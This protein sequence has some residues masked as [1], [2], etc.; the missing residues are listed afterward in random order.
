MFSL[1]SQT[2]QE[3][4]TETLQLKWASSTN[5]AKKTQRLS[6]HSKK[7]DSSKVYNVVQGSCHS[8]WSS[9]IL[10]FFW[11]PGRIGSV[12]LHQR[13]VQKK[14][15][16]RLLFFRAKRE[17]KDRCLTLKKGGNGRFVDDLHVHLIRRDR[18]RWL[19]G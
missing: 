1:V 12:E 3:K 13:H 17:T 6:R 19:S 5:E 7:N 10:S 14:E 4:S 8:F 2:K 18:Y 11:R 9:S 16:Q 15:D